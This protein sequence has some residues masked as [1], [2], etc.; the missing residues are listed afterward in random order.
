MIMS[1][2]DNDLYKF[3]VSYFAFRNY[4]D[5]I[6]KYNLYNR[7][8]PLSLK[9]L[10]P[11]LEY[12]EGLKFEQKEINWLEKRFPWFS[13]HWLEWLEG[14]RFKR[15]EVTINGD[16]LTITGPWYRTTLW[17]VVLM[18]IIS[19]L[20]NSEHNYK[21]ITE[22]DNSFAQLE[23]LGI[24]WVD[25]GTRRRQNSRFHDEIVR[26]MSRHS[27]FKG[28]S[29][30]FLAKELA[31]NPIGSVP[32][33]ILMASQCFVDKSSHEDLLNEIVFIEK[34]FENIK[35]QK[36]YLPDT[37]STKLFLNSCDYYSS[38]PNGFRVDSGNEIEVTNLI[39][40]YWK[41]EQ[42]PIV[43]Y[44]NALKP[45]RVIEIYNQVKDKVV[46]V[47]GIGTSL[48]NSLSNTPCNFV[49]KLI[50]INGQPVVKLSN[51]KGKE[52][53][54][55]KMIEKLRKMVENANGN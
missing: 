8:K 11:C 16:E 47:F 10:K 38:N 42:K 21:D 22:I 40:K 6:A 53:G 41:S 29:N 39:L 45:N 19:E 9:K 36:I 14:F 28:T 23:R 34:W 52:T 24:D 15:S 54:D 44:S 3:F 51:D 50:E 18:A 31:L 2:L 35:T 20:N 17:E 5:A 1:M 43:I 13:S 46:P 26:L 48:T 49:I 55:L 25:F 27:H 30:L 37:I 33:E 4:P 32:H 7:G 12:L